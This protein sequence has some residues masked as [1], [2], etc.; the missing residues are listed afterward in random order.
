[1]GHPREPEMGDGATT[2]WPRGVQ[3]N[4][5][6]FW[7]LTIDANDPATL[8]RFWAKVLGY[9]PVPP[10]GPETWHAL[11][12]QRLGER[13]AFDNRLF[14]PAG[15]RPPIFFQQ[16]PEHKAGKNRVHID[17]Y[18]TGRD[19]SL[20]QERR[21]E[22]VEGKVAELVELGGSVVHRNRNDDPDDPEYFVVMR[23]PE[24]NEFC[25]S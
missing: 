4:A 12:R 15:A 24:G 17:V 21:I 25:V 8:V 14:D 11:Y 9:E 16:V 6:M 2:A 5:M 10:E 23:D 19:S 18:P 3:N 1:M 22:L 13:A 20:P 7:Q